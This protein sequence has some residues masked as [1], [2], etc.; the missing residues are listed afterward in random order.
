MN[1]TKAERHARAVRDGLASRQKCSP[2]H[3]D[4]VLMILEYRKQGMTLRAIGALYNLGESAIC[5]VV[6]R[7]RWADVSEATE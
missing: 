1:E 2:L 5:R 6:N 7:S 4:D 3:P